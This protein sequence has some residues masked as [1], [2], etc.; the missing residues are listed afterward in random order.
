M[1]IFWQLFSCF[2]K[3]KINFAGKKEENGGNGEDIRGD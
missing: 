2:S 3:K 1:Q